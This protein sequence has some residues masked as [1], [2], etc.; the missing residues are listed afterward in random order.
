M[1]QIN[2]LQT[3]LLNTTLSGGVQPYDPCATWAGDYI[4]ANGTTGMLPINGGPYSNGFA[5]IETTGPCVSQGPARG[6]LTG[7]FYPNGFTGTVNFWTTAKDASG[8]N[9]ESNHLTYEVVA[10][11]ALT[12][13]AGDDQFVNGNP[14]SIL[15]NGASVSGGGGSYTYMW[16]AP[17]TNP[18]INTPFSPS[19]LVLNPGVG[20]LAANGN[21]TFT[22][23]ATDTVT[24]LTGSD[25]VIINVSGNIPPPVVGPEAALWLY[26]R[27]TYAVGAF[28]VQRKRGTTTTTILTKNTYVN[29]LT[30]SIAVGS[31]TLQIQDGDQIKITVDSVDGSP[32]SN[33]KSTCTGFLRSKNRSTGATGSIWTGNSTGAV[34]A[35]VSI[36]SGFVTVSPSTYQYE[37]QAT[38]SAWL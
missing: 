26:S 17:L 23:T 19:T 24:G 30:G 9:D 35:A 36:T 34:G 6:S 38:A 22:L 21:Y 27:G 25:S 14:P 3:I 16:S 10:L 11:N 37:I 33:L 32:S 31:G 15:L 29:G 5:Y 13:N 4:A 7:R 20:N 28:T 18:Y 12:V 2:T 1:S 8:V